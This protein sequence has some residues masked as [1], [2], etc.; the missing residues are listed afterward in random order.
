MIHASLQHRQ[1]LLIA[2]DGMVVRNKRMMRRFD[3]I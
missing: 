3:L 2:A 1:F